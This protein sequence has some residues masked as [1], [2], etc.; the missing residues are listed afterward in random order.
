MLSGGGE[1]LLRLIKASAQSHLKRQKSPKLPCLVN[2]PSSYGR[3]RSLVK[4][5]FFVWVVEC[6][7]HRAFNLEML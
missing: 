7:T 3:G 5:L 4:E 6:S 1:V 2:L